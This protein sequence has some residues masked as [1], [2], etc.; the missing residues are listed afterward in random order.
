MMFEGVTITKAFA[1]FWRNFPIGDS[2]RT[3][4]H[5]GGSGHRR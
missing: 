3:L 2:N 4:F 5:I 1:A